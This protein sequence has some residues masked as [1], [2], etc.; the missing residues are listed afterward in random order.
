MH[1]ESLTANLSRHCLMRIGADGLGVCD[2]HPPAGVCC[3]D[4][5]QVRPASAHHRVLHAS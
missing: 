5:V 4:A 1:K 3:V 2:R